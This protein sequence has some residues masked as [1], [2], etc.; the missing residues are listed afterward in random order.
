MTGTGSPTRVISPCRASCR[1]C[2]LPVWLSWL[3]GQSICEACQAAFVSVVFCM[4]QES[5]PASSVPDWQV[6]MQS[7]VVTLVASRRSAPL[8]T[9]GQG[10]RTKILP[11]GVDCLSKY[12]GLPATGTTIHAMGATGTMVQLRAVA[13]VGVPRMIIPLACAA[14][15]RGELRVRTQAGEPSVC[16]I[17][18]STNISFNEGS[19]C[20]SRATLGGGVGFSRSAVARRGACDGQLVQ[21]RPVYMSQAD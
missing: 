7:F 3:P 21:E 16:E 18:T 20:S 12:L 9:A 4:R 13:H 8:Q 15:V 6:W 2:S 11:R 1:P 14:H 19:S 5:G 10:E 17:D